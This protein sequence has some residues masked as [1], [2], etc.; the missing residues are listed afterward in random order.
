LP[1]GFKQTTERWF[2]TDAVTVIPY[3]YGNLGR[4]VLRQDG[5]QNVDLGISKR[6]RLTE[7]VSMDFRSEFFNLFNHPNFA[8]PATTFS[9]PGNFGRVFSIVGSPRVIQFGLKLNF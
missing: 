9:D 6:T 4:N 5:F 8:A 3:T 7:T 2:N 1:S